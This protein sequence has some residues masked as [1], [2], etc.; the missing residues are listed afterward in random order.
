MLNSAEKQKQNNE[1]KNNFI[2]SNKV[3]TIQNNKNL[4]KLIWIR[5]NEFKKVNRFSVF[6]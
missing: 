4:Q 3:F 6:L 2:L 1:P 5:S